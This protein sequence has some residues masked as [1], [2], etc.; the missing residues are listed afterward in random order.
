ML[1]ELPLDELIQHLIHHREPRDIMRARRH[2]LQ[3]ALL[4]RL[5]LQQNPLLLAAQN[6]LESLQ[7]LTV[8]PAALLVAHVLLLE[9]LE[10]LH[11][12]YRAGLG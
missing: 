8:L 7:V 6:L 3:K 12:F 11:V 9:I 1:V 2:G 5:L 4:L 10:V